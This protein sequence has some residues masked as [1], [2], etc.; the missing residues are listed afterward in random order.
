MTDKS[1]FDGCQTS[2]GRSRRNVSE[3]DGLPPCANFVPGVVNGTFA[4]LSGSSTVNCILELHE[5]GVRAVS[6]APNVQ[7]HNSFPRRAA[8]RRNGMILGG[9][10]LVCASFDH[11]AAVDW[12]SSNGNLRFRAIS[13]ERSASSRISTRCTAF[14]T[15]LTVSQAVAL[16]HRT[17]RSTRHYD[18]CANVLILAQY[19]RAA[20]ARERMS[21]DFIVSR[22]YLN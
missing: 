20:R 17:D 11:D 19:R 18:R 9:L 2:S 1:R 8:S 12:G 7:G 3:Y 6:F 14:Q 15:S 5:R 10:R 22:S 16:G 21:I 13:P 4:S